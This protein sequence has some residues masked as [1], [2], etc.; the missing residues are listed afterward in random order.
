[1]K[2]EVRIDE[3]SDVAAFASKLASGRGNA[4]SQASAIIECMVAAASPLIGS[5][6]SDGSHQDRLLFTFILAGACTNFNKVSEQNYG[7]KIEVSPGTVA[8]AFRVYQLVT[9]KDIKPCLPTE[10]VKFAE[11]RVLN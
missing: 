7:M 2:P 1:M 8:E 4:S 3:V 9:G 11:A 10:M 5:L 6:F